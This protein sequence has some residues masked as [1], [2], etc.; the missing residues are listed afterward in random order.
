MKKTFDYNRARAYARSGSRSD[1][2]TDQLSLLDRL[3]GRFWLLVVPIVGL[4]LVLTIIIARTQASDPQQ[5][6]GASELLKLL[7]IETQPIRGSILQLR[8]KI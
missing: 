1:L 5:A 4:S 8:S 7:Y 2:M 6:N 3:K